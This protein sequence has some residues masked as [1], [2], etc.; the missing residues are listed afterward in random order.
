[1]GK[2]KRISA[3]AI[4]RYK[5]FRNAT[6]RA[7]EEILLNRQIEISVES[8]KLFAEWKK[9]IIMAMALSHGRINLSHLYSQLTHEN[10]QS[11]NKLANIFIRTKR[12]AFI[13]SMAAEAEAIAQITGKGT[14][15]LNNNKIYDSSHTPVMEKTASFENRIKYLLDKLARKLM[16]S[17]HLGL[18]KG[19]T[20]HQIERRIDRALPVRKTAP[21]QLRV[22]SKIA[23]ARAPS[24]KQFK[25]AMSDT[26]IDDGTWK[27]IVSDYKD[28]H[29]PD[30]RSDPRA[31]YTSD[32]ADEK[33][34]AW[35]LENEL[36]EDFVSS[37]REGQVDA[38]SQNGVQDF[39]WIAIID[40]K[41][42]DCCL[43]RDGKLSSEIEEELNSGDHQD[44]DC[45]ASV[46]PAH[47]NCRCRIAPYLNVDENEL[48]DNTEE[49]SE[50]LDQ[51]A[52]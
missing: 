11:A 6:D 13:L 44:D 17:V 34:S 45:D 37:V 14:S 7:L 51:K 20:L 31:M 5:R 52:Q 32:A 38:F 29:V 4:P 36:M 24:D 23:E 28:N 40:D 21:K 22:L 41:T 18:I 1:M 48:P 2:D 26:F 8:A 16:D 10:E 50:W 46:P 9:A 25:S 33:I 27:D 3:L 15:S 47:P 30:F 42:D 35:E 19:E 43:W 39:V 12:T 49:F